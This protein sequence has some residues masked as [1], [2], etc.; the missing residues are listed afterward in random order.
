VTEIWRDIADYEGIY[1]ISNF[2]R[3]KSLTRKIKGKKCTS[4]T[5]KIL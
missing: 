3:V 5:K 1:Q 4:M 2:G